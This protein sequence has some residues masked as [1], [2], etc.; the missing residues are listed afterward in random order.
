MMISLLMILSSSIFEILEFLVFLIWL[1]YA[2]NFVCL[3]IL[4]RRKNKEDKNIRF[5]ETD[6]YRLEVRNI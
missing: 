6:N 1:F 2:L 4:K 3:I 5:K